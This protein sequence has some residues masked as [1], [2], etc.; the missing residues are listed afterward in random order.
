MNRGDVLYFPDFEFEDGGH[1]NKLFVV[2]AAPAGGERMLAMKT[3][4]V[5]DKRKRDPG[6]Q[7]AKKEFF[8]KAGTL[9]RKDTWII[10]WTA[11][12]VLPVTAVAEKIKKNECKI[13]MTLPSQDVNAIRNC[14]EKFS[15]DLNQ[16][17][18][19]M[20]R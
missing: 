9:F 3:T 18:R 2:L 12:Y 17:H 10:L 14:L 13:V 1:A 6:C 8:F 15:E 11:P 20:L 19:D 7:P 4:S 16:E 5:S